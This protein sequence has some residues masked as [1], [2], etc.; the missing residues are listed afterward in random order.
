MNMSMNERTTPSIRNEEFRNL[1]I[2][3]SLNTEK[4]PLMDKG[5]SLTTVLFCMK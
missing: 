2:L 5:A 3:E 4:N 1:A